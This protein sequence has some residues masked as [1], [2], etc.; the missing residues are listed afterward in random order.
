MLNV[1]VNCICDCK[2]MMIHDDTEWYMMIHDDQWWSMIV[3][4]DPWTRQCKIC[5]TCRRCEF[6]NGFWLLK[7]LGM[8]ICCDGALKRVFV[9]KVKL[10]EWWLQ[11]KK[12]NHE[13]SIFECSCHASF[14]NHKGFH[15]LNQPDGISESHWASSHKS[16]ESF[17]DKQTYSRVGS[18]IKWQSL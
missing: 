15:S 8:K 5:K 10:T 6:A 12:G 16:V 9:L 4:D 14:S 7:G 18:S 13:A 17:T 3:N 11:M 2:W 1:I